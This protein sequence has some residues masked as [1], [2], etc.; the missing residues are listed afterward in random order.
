M[1]EEASSKWWIELRS[2]QRWHL[3]K[4]LPVTFRFS[5]CGVIDSYFAVFQLPFFFSWIEISRNLT[6]LYF[7]HA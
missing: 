3:R 1:M 7:P 2:S 4:R 5:Q 6:R